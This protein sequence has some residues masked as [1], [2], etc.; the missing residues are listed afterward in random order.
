MCDVWDKGDV[1]ESLRCVVAASGETLGSVT[2]YTE[3]EPAA[4]PHDAAAAAAARDAPPQGTAAPDAAAP[5]E[6]STAAAAAPEDAEMQDADAAAPAHPPAAA[7]TN[8]AAAGPA[9]AGEAADQGG[10]EEAA[11]AQGS[12]VVGGGGSGAAGAQDDA[13]DGAGATEV[14]QGLLGDGRGSSGW[15]PRNAWLQAQER[16]EAAMHGLLPGE[17]EQNAP[18]LGAL[19]TQPLP[20]MQPSRSPAG[21]AVVS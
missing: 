7:P 14:V 16:L 13:M 3:A 5:A 9:D 18:R 4:A 21:V 8:V 1:C 17:S 10:G 6:A 12:G 20:G 19:T 15:F 2:R 11:A